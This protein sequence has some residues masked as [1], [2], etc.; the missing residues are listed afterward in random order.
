MDQKINSVRIKIEQDRIFQ[1]M[2]M[3]HF[4]LLDLVYIIYPISP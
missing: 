4:L 1:S 3:K 2:F